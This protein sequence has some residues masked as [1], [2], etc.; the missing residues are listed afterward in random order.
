MAPLGNAWHIPNN[1]QPA[2]RE[3]MRSPVGSIIPGTEVTVVNGNQF[4]NGTGS[5]DQFRAGSLVHFRRRGDDAWSDRQ[6]EFDSQFGNDKF[7]IARLATAGFQLGDIVEYYLEIAY[8]PAQ[9]DTTFLCSDGAGASKTVGTKAEAEAALFTIALSPPGEVGKWS[10]EIKLQNVP[11]HTH[12]LPNGLVLYWGRRT[13]PGDTNLTLNDHLTRTFI[14]DPATKTDRELLSQPSLIKPS[15]QR[16]SINLFCSGHTF[17][18][19][20]RL[21]VVGGHLYD[22]IGI[23]QSSIFNFNDESWTP[24]QSRP[25]GE[26]DNNEQDWAGRDGRWYPSVVSLADGRVMTIS[27]S[28]HT[29]PLP[30]PF[31]AATPDRNQIQ[32][33]DHGAVWDGENWMPFRDFSNDTSLTMPLFPRLHSAPDGTVFMAGGLAESF[34]LDV[35]KTPLDNGSRWQPGPLRAAKARDYA[36]SVMY[37]AGKIVFIGGGQNILRDKNG[38]FISDTT[39]TGDQGGDPT[40]IVEAIDLNEKPLAWTQKA[41]MLFPRRQHNGTILPDGTVLVTGGSLRGGFNN[42]LP[43]NPVHVAEL[44]DPVKNTWMLL[45]AETFDRCYHSTSVLLPDATVFSGGGGEYSPDNNDIPNAPQDSHKNAQI[46]SPPYLFDGTNLAVRPQ[47]TKELPPVTYGEKFAVSV[48]DPAAIK[49]VT[50]VRLPSVTHSFDQNQRLNFLTFEASGAGITFTAPKAPKDCPPGHYML[51]VLSQKG[52]PSVAK[53][54]QIKLPASSPARPVPMA[55]TLKQFKPLPIVSKFEKS[56]RIA[57]SAEFPSVRVGITATCPYGLSACWGPAH[58][59]L[60][61]MTGVRIVRPYAN[62]EDSTALVYLTH[63]GLPDPNEWRWEFAEYANGSHPFR[64]IEVRLAGRVEETEAGLVMKAT[65]DR[66]EV[67]LLPIRPQDKLQWNHSARAVK[68]LTRRETLAFEKLL[69]RVRNQAGTP[70]EARVIGTLK[71]DGSGFQLYVRITEPLIRRIMHAPMSEIGLRREPAALTEHKGGLAPGFTPDKRN[72]LADNDGR[73]IAELSYRNFFLG[74]WDKSDR[75]NIDDALTAVMTDKGLNDILAQYFPGQTIRSIPLVSQ[76][77]PSPKTGTVSRA[78]VEDLV[79]QRHADGT[80]GAADFPNTVFNFLLPRGVILTDDD[81]P[82][83]EDVV[84]MKT[85]GGGDS[86]L[87]RPREDDADD[88]RA[89]LGGFHGSIEVTAAD[90]KTLTI[91]YAVGVFSELS[92][93]VPN[94][95]P[96]FSDPWKNVV[97]TFYHELTEART[98]PDVESGNGTGN[99]ALFG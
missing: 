59:A 50:W 5:G 9:H 82:A 11:I 91:Y 97:A 32:I 94:G 28:Y 69:G 21:M 90:E 85:G 66:P 27:G 65:D 89:G 14:F 23:N 44:W 73:K 26:T 43:G 95:I 19:D 39:D 8:A 20:G 51:F 96:V 81:A 37:D 83:A 13:T 98:D 12:V 48:D 3:G 68:P 45:A 25:D 47:I 75:K 38:N 49:T 54:V 46:F 86:S 55:V 74:E 78:D 30:E 16:Q 61:Y 56:K 87:V 60:Q 24:I 40:G 79:R 76:T 57:A 42:L 77:L 71:K 58:E 36:P 17:L 80:L 93:G 35:T 64:G 29:T 99:A 2:G 1:P 84:E 62:Y 92:N 10:D 22:G 70:L 53:I 88:S 33:N 34:T 67:L 63:P 72:N 6:M 4:Q 31:G 18:P 41:N 52:V 7:F 15:G